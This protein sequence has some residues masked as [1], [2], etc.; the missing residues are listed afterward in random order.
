MNKEEV[1]QEL[2]ER[3]KNSDTDNVEGILAMQVDLRDQDG[4]TLYLEIK[5]KVLS[6]EPYEYY[7]RNVVINILSNDLLDIADKKLDPNEAISKEILS[8]DGDFSKALEIFS[9][10]KI[11][12]EEKQ[13]V[14]AEEKIE[15]K[16]VGEKS[17]PKAKSTKNTSKTAKK[18]STKTTAKSST[19][20][21]SKNKSK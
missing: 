15:V 21:T 2:R 5:D 16:K 14:K 9:L 19:K 13:E 3:F 4:G 1:V 17:S 6:I 20:K 18:T 12:I 8:V 10:S 7:D 11:K